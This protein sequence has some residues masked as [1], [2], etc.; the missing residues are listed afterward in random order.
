[1]DPLLWKERKESRSCGLVHLYTE[2]YAF[3][4][5]VLSSGMMMQ[6]F[7]I[8]NFM[9]SLYLSRHTGSSAS[10]PGPHNSRQ[11]WTDWKGS[12]GVHEDE[13]ESL[14]SE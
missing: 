13:Q 14:S 5:P 9:F 2:L 7:K 11:T 8:A 6:I 12:K 4:V 1:M 10:S 3:C